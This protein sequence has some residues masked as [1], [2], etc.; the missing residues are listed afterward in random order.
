MAEAVVS[1]VSLLD[2]L[3]GHV[4]PQRVWEVSTQTL[5]AGLTGSKRVSSNI[6]SRY[7]VTEGA[8]TPEPRG[9]K[10]EVCRK[11]FHYYWSLKTVVWDGGSRWLHLLERTC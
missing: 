6:F 9:H 7:R 3:N 10:A 4:C 5:S 2:L 1:A 8:E 11:T